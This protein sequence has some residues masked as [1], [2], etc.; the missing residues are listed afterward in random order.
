V[1]QF[2]DSRLKDSARRFG[3]IMVA[4]IEAG[5]TPED[6][7]GLAIHKLSDKAGSDI[8]VVPGTPTQA[9][10]QAALD[11]LSADQ[12]RSFIEAVRPQREN[13]NANN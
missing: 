2:I 13:R 6:M 3:R 11:A 7:V 9:E 8:A 12:L 10:V 5:M 1:Y 4:A